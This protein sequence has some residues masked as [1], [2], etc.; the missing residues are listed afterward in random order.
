M[1]FFLTEVDMVITLDFVDSYIF[2]YHGK[3][4]NLPIN[5]KYSSVKPQL[6][7]QN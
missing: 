2:N 1:F 3:I 5:L 6:G 4:P 7:N